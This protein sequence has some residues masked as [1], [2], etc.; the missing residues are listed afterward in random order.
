[1][2]RHTAVV[3]RP[4]GDPHG[5]IYCQGHDEP[6]V[7]VGVLADEIDTSGARTSSSG[8]WPKISANF[9]TVARAMGIWAIM[10][11]SAGFGLCDGI[12]L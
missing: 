5:P 2:D 4:Q 8:G 6:V 11:S 3:A 1:M 9:F 7:V 12:E 10:D